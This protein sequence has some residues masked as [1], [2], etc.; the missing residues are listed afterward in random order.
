M[1][2]CDKLPKLRKNNNFSQEQFAEKLNVSRQAVSKWESGLSYP[3][4]DKMLQMC[5]ILN[6]TLEELLDDGAI[7][8]NNIPTQKE[9]SVSYLQDFLSFITKIYNMFLSMTWKEKIKCIIEMFLV[10]CFVIF[11]E[12]VIYFGIN[13]ILESFLSLFY[14]NGQYRIVNFFNLL[15]LVLLIILGLIIVLHLFKI[16]YLDYF[17]TIEDNMVVEKSIEKPIEIEKTNEEKIEKKFLNSNREKVIIRDPKHSFLSFFRFLGQMIKFLFKVFVFFICFILFFL[18]IF[19]IIGLSFS[20]FYF[21]YGSLFLFLA[22]LFLGC[23]FFILVFIYYFYFFIADKKIDWKKSFVMLILSLIFVG[24]GIAGSFVTV[25]NYEHPTDFS[26]V[27]TETSV[28]IIDI[29]DNT[30]FYYYNS[31]NIIFDIDD[32]LKKAKIEITTIKG[33][34]YDLYHYFD[35][36]LDHYSIYLEDFDFFQLY[37]LIKNDL[38]EKKIRNYTESDVVKIKV[39]LSSEDYMILRN[40]NSVW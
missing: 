11:I 17:V 30:E 18:F 25:L 35:D 29:K 21:T 14:F 15:S 13:L 34:K 26:D 27:E 9:A 20:I 1:R 10:T 2:F 36:S 7:S 4:M 33:M 28:E 22:L 38:K 19:S 24:S 6:C 16:R 37:E 8:K 3:D 23:S 39:T 40:N 12:A 32:S 31:D 5:K